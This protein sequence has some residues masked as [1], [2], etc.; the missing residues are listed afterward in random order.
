MRSTAVLPQRGGAGDGDLLLLV[1]AQALLPTRSSMPGMPMSKVTSL[2][3]HAAARS[4][5]P[6]SWNLPSASVGRKPGAR[7]AASCTSPDRR[8]VVGRRSRWSDSRS[9]GGLAKGADHLSAATPPIVSTPSDSVTSSSRMP[10]RR[11]SARRPNRRTHGHDLVRV[12]LTMFALPVSF[13]RGP[14]TAGIH[15]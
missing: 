4:R 5:M 8:L 6:V 7:P 15:G 3:R 2:L 11:R 1:G 13:H 12:L 10:R 14:R 9:G